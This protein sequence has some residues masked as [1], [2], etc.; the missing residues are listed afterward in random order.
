MNLYVSFREDF[1]S[2]FRWNIIFLYILNGGKIINSKLEANSSWW[3]LYFEIE[4]W[5]G[6]LRDRFV[7]KFEWEIGF[8]G[9]MEGRWNVLKA[10]GSSLWL[11]NLDDLQF[12]RK[13]LL[14]ILV[15]SSIKVAKSAFFSKFSISEIFGLFIRSSD[16]L[17]V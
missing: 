17:H 1:F 2:V 15:N 3:N 11:G 12:Y 8:F 14:Q 16:E 7:W 13:F 5:G 6:L 10:C 4:F 9:G